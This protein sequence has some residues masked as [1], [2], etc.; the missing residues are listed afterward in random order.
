MD[1]LAGLLFF[2]SDG[3]ASFRKC[4]TARAATRI[5]DIRPGRRL[6]NAVTI[7]AR[8]GRGEPA[9]RSGDGVRPG[10]VR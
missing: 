2:G 7:A 10:S 4:G 8:A 6:R 5:A 9:R 1:A 3:I